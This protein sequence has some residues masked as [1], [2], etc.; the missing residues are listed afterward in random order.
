MYQIGAEL[1][2]RVTHLFRSTL[3]RLAKVSRI[4]GAVEKLQRFA[5]QPRILGVVK[6]ITA[7]GNEMVVN[8]DDCQLPAK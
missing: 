1:N 6:K 3:Q 5:K 8:V 2:N 4:L 7:A